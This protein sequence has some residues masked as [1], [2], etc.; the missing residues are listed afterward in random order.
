MSVGSLAAF[1]ALDALR[2]VFPMA[3]ALLLKTI[4]EMLPLISAFGSYDFK[5]VITVSFVVFALEFMTFWWEL[6]CW[7]D[8]RL[9]EAFYN[10]DTHSRWNAAGFQSSSDGLIMNFVMGTMLPAL[11][12]VAFL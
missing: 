10:S 11:W 5:T 8:R 1:P 6:S 3:Q 9:V 4:Y 7:P 12:M 2:Q